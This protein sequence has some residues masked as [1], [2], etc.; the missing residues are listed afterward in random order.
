[1]A[2]YR[3]LW[4]YTASVAEW[5]RRIAARH[6]ALRTAATERGVALDA[7]DALFAP[8]N[9]VQTPVRLRRCPPTVEWRA[10]DA[11][12]PSQILQLVSDVSWLVR[13]TE[14]KPVEIGDPGVFSDHIGIPPFDEL[15]RLEADAIAHGLRSASVREYLEQMLFDPTQYQPLSAQL[16]TRQRITERTARQLRLAAAARLRDDVDALRQ[17]EFQELSQPTAGRIDF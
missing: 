11:A 3:D 7:F 6:R 1:M 12:L 16:P 8:E 2:P 5:D 15:R 13:Q 17:H 10:P 4:E 14:N 9:S